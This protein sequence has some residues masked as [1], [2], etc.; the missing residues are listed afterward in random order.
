MKKPTARQ[1]V[2]SAQRLIDILDHFAVTRTPETLSA[3]ASRLGL[4]KSSC[5]ALLRTLETNGYL[6]EVTPK[7][8]YY[9]TRRWFDR[10]RVIAESDP[11]IEKVKPLME[12][13]SEETRETLIF[14]KRFGHQVMYIDALEWPQTLRYTAAAGQFKPLH[15][16]AS[17]KAILAGMNPT[18]RNALLDDYEFQKITPR[19]IMQRGALEKELLAGIKRGWHISRGENEPDT[20]AVAVPIVVA[21]DVFVLAVGGVRSRI[22][23]KAAK[24]GDML[25]KAISKQNFS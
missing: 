5:F 1:T 2:K 7:I 13:L 3:L 21:S 9:P 18:E 22:E 24:I 23:R 16:T 25:F 20:T 4:P 15:C 10:G 14:G 17:G 11:L 8:G 12:K 6:Y 19:T